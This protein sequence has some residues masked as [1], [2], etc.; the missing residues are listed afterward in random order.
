MIRLILIIIFLILFFTVGQL[1]LLIGFLLSIFDKELEYKFYKRIINIVFDVI[2]FISGVSVEVIGKEN[3]E[4]YLN[5]GVSKLLISNHRSFFDIIAGYG[6]YKDKVCYMSK[7]ELKKFFLLKIWMD[8]INCIFIDRKNIKEA[9]KSIIVAI[10]NIQN[11]ISVWIFPEGTRN[12]NENQL[13]LLEFK[14][15]SFSIAKKTGCEIV[16]IAFLNTDDVFEKHFPIIKKTKVK[17]II[18]KSFFVKDLDSEYS[19]RVSVYAMNEIKKLM[20]LG[21][22]K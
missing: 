3:S 12:K 11:G 16:P 9:M 20:K 13:D 19:D 15:G 1:S 10:R 21:I 8:K 2:L 6:I 14:E 18:G 7:D 17:V 22:D 4:T 5:N